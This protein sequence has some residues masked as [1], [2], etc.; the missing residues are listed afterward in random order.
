MGTK[1]E[2]VNGRE[3]MRIRIKFR[4]SSHSDVYTIVAVYKTKVDAQHAVGALRRLLTDMKES[5]DAYDTDWGAEDASATRSE[6]TVK[7]QVY[8]AG[9]LE[10]PV[11]TLEKFAPDKIGTYENYQDLTIQV[12]LPKKVTFKIAMICLSKD[13]A[14]AMKQLVNKIGIPEIT[15]KKGV[16]TLTWKY[17]GNRL[18]DEDDQIL[19]LDEEFQIDKHPNWLVTLNS[20]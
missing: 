15:I 10:D 14:E 13:E 5:P 6:R 3:K 11:A 9:T 1:D 20:E 17:G 19:L 12:V 16:Q 2:K 4:S 8:T 18:Y 7:L